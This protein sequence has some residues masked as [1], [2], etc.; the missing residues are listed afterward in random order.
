[1]TSFC[2]AEQ[3]IKARH[4]TYYGNKMNRLNYWYAFEMV[5]VLYLL[6]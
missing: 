5:F 6:I 3:V 1:M 4:I 2:F